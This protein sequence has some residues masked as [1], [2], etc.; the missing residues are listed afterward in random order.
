MFVNL[1]FHCLFTYFS[2]YAIIVLS[3][4]TKGESKMTFNQYLAEKR[5]NWVDKRVIYAGDSNLYT[6]VGIDANGCLLINKPT[7]FT[8]T[9]AVETWHVQEI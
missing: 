9:T 4:N 3:Y 6:V 8:D 7:R 1:L 5:A 2:K